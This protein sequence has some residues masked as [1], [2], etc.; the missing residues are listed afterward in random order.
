[1]SKPSKEQ[2]R[3]QFGIPDW[4]DASAYPIAKTMRD[5]AWRW[6][7][8]RRLK[9]YRLDWQRS[10][11]GA[12]IDCA[13]KYGLAI[14]VDPR[15]SDGY[16]RFNRT[17]TY[18]R[19]S[20]VDD[21]MAVGLDPWQ[22]DEEHFNHLRGVLAYMRLHLNWSHIERGHRKKWPAYLRALDADAENTDS[23]D[24]WQTIY[25]KG[26]TKNPRACGDGLVKQ[27]RMVRE[28]ITNTRIAD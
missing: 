18:V 23:V 5:N 8:V 28:L 6:E 19:G 17:Q 7:F 4:R 26:Q 11:K 22:S 15:S 16:I 24:I 27:A 21:V 10:R 13:A 20:T 9:D 14:M 12:T 1:M 25:P 2:I 3:K